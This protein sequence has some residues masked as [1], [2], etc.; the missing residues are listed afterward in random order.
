MSSAVKVAVI[1]TGSLG[2]EHAR[3]Y[4]ELVSSGAVEFTGLFD[5]ARETAER[6]TASALFWISR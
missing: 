6:E 4:S 3:I 5:T 2:K 1:G